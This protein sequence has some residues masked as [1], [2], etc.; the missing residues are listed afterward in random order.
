M[1]ITTSRGEAGPGQGESRETRDLSTGD[2][3]PGPDL[4]LPSFHQPGPARQQH[5]GHKRGRGP[6]QKPPRPGRAAARRHG[7]GAGYADYDPRPPP[8]NIFPIPVEFLQ[9]IN[10]PGQ[11]KFR[12]GAEQFS[13]SAQIEELGGGGVEASSGPATADTFSFAAPQPGSEGGQPSQLF[14]LEEG[15]TTPASS[16]PV[17]RSLGAGSHAHS[18]YREEY[19]APAPGPGLHPP[20]SQVPYHDARHTTPSSLQHAPQ[21]APPAKEK[22]LHYMAPPNQVTRTSPGTAAPHSGQ[23]ALVAA[24]RGD[25]LPLELQTNHR[26]FSQSQRKSQKDTMLNGH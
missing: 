12:P 24:D 2:T 23:L 6:R 9:Q 16:Q 4:R 25:Q 19:P 15:V 17:E 20:Y 3:Q 5:R 22:V 26:K 7:Q 1:V 11:G 10:G 18:I 8:P 14:T 13:P 21:H